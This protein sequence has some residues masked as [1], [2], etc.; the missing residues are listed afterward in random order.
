MKESK[1]VE[2]L[3]KEFGKNEVIKFS[4]NMKNRI[5]ILDCEITYKGQGFWVEIKMPG[6]KL[7]PMQ[8]A[9]MKRHYKRSACFKFNTTNIEIITLD[10]EGYPTFNYFRD[11]E[12]TLKSIDG[13]FINVFEALLNL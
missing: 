13:L 9:F 8:K 12:L 7:K 6:D 3:R 2:L 5:G 4:A 10:F 1:I 11:R